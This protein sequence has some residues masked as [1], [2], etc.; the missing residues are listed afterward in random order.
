MLVSAP[1]IDEVDELPPFRLTLGAWM[2]DQLLIQRDRLI[3]D[4]GAPVPRIDLVH[5]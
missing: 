1:G 3:R 2:I 5:E 4:L